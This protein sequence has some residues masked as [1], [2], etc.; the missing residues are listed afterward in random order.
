MPIH[1][2]EG[3]GLWSQTDYR[4]KARPADQTQ[5]RSQ[6]FTVTDASGADLQLSDVGVPNTDARSRKPLH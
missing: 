3:A 5:D 4:F 6:Y 2:Y 1:Q